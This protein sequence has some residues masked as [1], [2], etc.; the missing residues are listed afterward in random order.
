MKESDL[1]VDVYSQAIHN[2]NKHIIITHLPT[3]ISVSGEGKSESYI[4]SR[5]MKQLKK[6]VLKNDK[7]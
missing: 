7:T 5:L 1:R 2:G 4:K 6:K 3:G